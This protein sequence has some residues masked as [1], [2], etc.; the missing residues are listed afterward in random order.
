MGGRDASSYQ[1]REATER[2]FDEN[3]GWLEGT[4][5]SL[6]LMLARPE[7][8]LFQREL[9]TVPGHPQEITPL[10]LVGWMETHTDYMLT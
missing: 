10:G 8:F 4:F 5:R 3:P 7:D 1:V 9:R 2:I 6:W